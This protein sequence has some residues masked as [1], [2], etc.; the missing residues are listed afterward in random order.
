MDLNKYAPVGKKYCEG[1]CN[2]RVVP[3]HDGPVVVCEGCE[4]IVIDKRK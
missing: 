3:T 1:N 2:T 4:R